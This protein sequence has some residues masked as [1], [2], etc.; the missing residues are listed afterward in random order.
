[1]TQVKNSSKS[2]IFI[3]S[4]G[5]SFVKTSNVKNV[6]GFPSKVVAKSFRK[7][8]RRLARPQR[9][10]FLFLLR[11]FR[12]NKA[13]CVDL[14]QGDSGKIVRTNVSACV[15][16]CRVTSA[17]LSSR[18]ALHFWAPFS[19]VNGMSRLDLRANFKAHKMFE[20]ISANTLPTVLFI[21]GVLLLNSNLYL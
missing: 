13:V 12:W 16:I 7:Q 3:G 1:M 18:P 8:W 14:S 15:Y 19:R 17:I 20:M 11:C 21:D 2:G 9:E 6:Y 10:D 5:Q 4:V